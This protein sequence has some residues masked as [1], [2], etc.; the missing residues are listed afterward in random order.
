MNIIP[1]GDLAS[2]LDNGGA[3]RIIKTVK[4]RRVFR[5]SMAP[6]ETAPA[7]RNRILETAGRLFL[8]RGFVQVRSGDIAAEL[9]ISKA[10]LY[11]V[12]TGKEEI[13]QHIVFIGSKRLR[14]FRHR[15]AEIAF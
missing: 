11:R 3:G 13:R 7:L 1:A 14:S 9:G 15:T 6:L 10:T 2:G 8:S 12:F 4:T 5:V